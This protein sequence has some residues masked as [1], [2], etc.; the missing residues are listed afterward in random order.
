MKM[1]FAKG[2]DERGELQFQRRDFRGQTDD[3]VF[4]LPDAIGIVLL[5]VQWCLAELI[6]YYVSLRGGDPDRTLAA[7]DLG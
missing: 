5:V 1:S 6:A 4:E 3:G 2:A 7:A